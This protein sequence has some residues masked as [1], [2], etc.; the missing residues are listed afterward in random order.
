MSAAESHD[1]FSSW[2]PGS[3]DG[4]PDLRVLERD[5]APR[6]ILTGVLAAILGLVP[7][8]VT[9]MRLPLQNLWGRIVAPDRMPRALLPLSQYAA[10]L[11]GAM[12]VC[13]WALAGIAARV[14]GRS[15]RRRGAGT[16]RAIILAGVG[17]LGVDAVAAG[18]SLEVVVSGLSPGAE[19]SIYVAAL[20]AV[21][22]AGVISGVI[23]LV[24]I[25]AARRPGAVVG[26]TLATVAAGEWVGG[27]IHVVGPIAGWS[28]VA[29]VFWYTARYLP[30]VLA[31]LAI[32]WGLSGARRDGAGSEQLRRAAPPKGDGAAARVIGAAVS[33]VLLWVLPAA[34]AAVQGAVGSRALLR[35][36]GELVRFALESFRMHLTAPGTLASVLL[37]AVIGAVGGSLRRWPPWRSSPP[38]GPGRRR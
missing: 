22:V 35:M 29:P 13:G 19:A 26:M 10:V 14:R 25:G 37:A 7:W 20:V 3:G 6:L 12:L 1:N 24:L 8:I 2:T 34:L 38:R 27:F 23:V 17:V 33:L 9:G 30:P 36:P 31:G 16:W 11:I 18:Q 15:S 28:P 21:I 32:A 5:N 4:D